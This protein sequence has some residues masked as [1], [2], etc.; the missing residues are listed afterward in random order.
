MLKYMSIIFDDGPNEYMPQMVDKFMDFGFKCGFA[1]IGRRFNDDTLPL[2]K[3]AIDNGCQIVAHGQN[4]V[5]VEKFDNINDME[6]E[7]LL[8]I[9]NLEKALGY[10][11]NMARLPYLSYDERVLE[12]AKKL[13]LPLL[14]QGIDGGRDW[15]EESLPKNIANAVINSACDGAIACLHVTKNT[16]KALDE[17][18]PELKKKG[19]DLVTPDEI[20]EKM[21]VKEIPLGIQIHNI[22]DILEG[23]I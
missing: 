4:H 22:N 12:C 10:K 21:G 5:H 3:Y 9:T 7:L 13:G 23:E 15:H 20:F 8:P 16:C 14:G 17:I 19:F 6:D 18:L 1:V 2:L 11:M